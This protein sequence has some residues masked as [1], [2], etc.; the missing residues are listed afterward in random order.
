MWGIISIS[1]H[2]CKKS[3]LSHTWTFVYPNGAL[4]RVS[5]LDGFSALCRTSFSITLAGFN[6][7]T[8]AVTR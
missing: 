1:G 7:F 6:S 5:L 3:V 4:A 2:G 8:T